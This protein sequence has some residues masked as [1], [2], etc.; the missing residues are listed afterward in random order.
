[1]S[2]YSHVTEKEGEKP[3]QGRKRTQGVVY[4]HLSAKEKRVGTEPKVGKPAPGKPSWPPTNSALKV[5]RLR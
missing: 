3:P 1:M 4:P 5:H 2:R